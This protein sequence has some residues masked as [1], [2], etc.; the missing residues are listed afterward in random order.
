MMAFLY[1]GVTPLHAVVLKNSLNGSPW[2]AF[3]GSFRLT[4]AF[5]D[6]ASRYDLINFKPETGDFDM[7]KLT[8]QFPY[9]RYFSINL[10]D[11]KDATDFA[12]L[13]DKEIIPDESSINPYEIN[14]DRN[15]ENRSY[16]LWI[17][18]EG[19]APPENASNIIT[20][21]K[22]IE[23]L[24]LMTRVYRPDNGKNS[25]GGV[26]LPIVEAI[27]TN[28]KTARQPDVGID[29]KGFQSKL[30]MFIFN[31]E[32]ITTWN[33]QKKFAKNEI[34][35]HRISDAGLFPN[36]HNEYI[37][38]P[39]EQCYWNKVAVVTLKNPPTFEDSYDGDNFA[40][41]KEVRYWSFCT[42]GLAETGTPDCLCDD[43][44]IMN[45]DDTVT[46]VIAPLYLKSK[47][48]NAGLNYMKWG[49]A[50]KPILIHRHMMASNDFY[51]RIGNVEYI[52]RPPG[53]ENR[54]AEYLNGHAAVNWMGDYTPKGFIYS[55]S[56]FNKKLKLGE[57]RTAFE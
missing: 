11:F 55:V 9:A 42:G 46:I 47:I 53:E 21:P 2:V 37:M 30:K 24:T 32:I 34:V 43:E 40:G 19:T 5:P 6:M 45:D 14:A 48:K 31:L 15:T 52:G 38:S 13:L 51:G 35:F 49:L 33:I 12:S 56:E 36:A 41:G 8:G 7:L 57:F 20:Y 10:Y 29:L 28:G 17:V 3:P 44:I 25:L 54:N 22:G 39:L 26:P 16:T 4:P 18:Q 27:K 23:A 50:Y 1:F